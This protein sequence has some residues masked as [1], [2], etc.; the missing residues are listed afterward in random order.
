MMRKVCLIVSSCSARYVGFVDLSGGGQD[1]MTVA[2]AHREKENVVVDAIREIRPPCSPESVVGEFATLLK[3]YS[4]T[5]IRGDRYAGEWPREQFSKRGIRYDLSEKS[6]SELYIE[7]LPMLNSGR[8]KLLDHA[9]LISQLCSLERRTARGGRDSID[10]PPR[11]HD[12][13]ANAVGGAILLAGKA[14]RPILISDAAL[15]R[16]MM[17]DPRHTVGSD[18]KYWWSRHA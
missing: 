12:D 8:V 5:S 17:P 1:S 2:I 18:N 15:A 10:H 6:K 16:S 3:A 14:S 9:R 11:A 4:I 7:L 13:V